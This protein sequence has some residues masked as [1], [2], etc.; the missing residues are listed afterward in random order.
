MNVMEPHL[1]NGQRVGELGVPS[2]TFVG[3]LQLKP[4]LISRRPHCTRDPA[5][6]ALFKQIKV[7]PIERLRLL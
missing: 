3:F 5:A 6:L 7:E 1:E 2:V 4:Q